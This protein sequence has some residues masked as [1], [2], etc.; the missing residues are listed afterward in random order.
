MTQD[1]AVEVENAAH[2]TMNSGVSILIMLRSPGGGFHKEL[3]LKSYFDKLL[4]V[5]STTGSIE[6]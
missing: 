6:N 4:F 2:I 5:K 1:I 3:R